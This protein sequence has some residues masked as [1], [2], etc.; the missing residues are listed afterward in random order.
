MTGCELD[1]K[2]IEVQFPAETRYFS[3]LHSV[4][5]D[6]GLPHNLLHNGYREAVYLG[7]GGRSVMLTINLHLTPRLI[8]TGS[9]YP[10]LHTPS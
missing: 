4:L 3:L 1:Y 5:T 7:E 8:I 2:G 9:I 6:S 10:F